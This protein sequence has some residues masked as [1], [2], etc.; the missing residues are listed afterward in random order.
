MVKQSDDSHKTYTV[1]K[2]DNPATI[3]KII[4]LIE[5]GTNYGTENLS[6]LDLRASKRIQL[7]GL[8]FRVDFDAYNIFNSDWP[9]TVSN[10]FSTAATA[11][12]LRPAN[13]LQARFF[14]V[15]LNFDF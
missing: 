6:Q 3:A 2:G 8:R 5:P 13:V 1:A 14:K 11:T 7:D 9:F 12:W 4:S 15:G 10:V